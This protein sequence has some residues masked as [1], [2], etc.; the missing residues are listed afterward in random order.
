M[1]E[2]NRI[3]LTDQELEDL[4]NRVF[5]P[6][7]DDRGVAVLCDLPDEALGEQEDWPWRRAT[8]RAWVEQIRRSSLGLP[9]ELYLYRNVHANNADLP[10]HACRWPGGSLPQNA[11]ALAG[12]GWE[13]VPFEQIFAQASIVLAPT[14]LS[15]TAPLKLAARREAARH[16]FR[17]ATLPGFNAAMIPALRLDYGEIDRRVRRLQDLLARAEG[18]RLTFAAF[19]REHE[20]F[21]DLRHRPAHASSGLCTES[22]YA[23]NVPS[24]EAYITPYEGERPDDPSRSQGVLPVELDGEV[25]LYQVVANKAVAVLGQGRVAIR[26]AALLAREPAYGNMAELGLGVLA[27]F[28]IAAIGQT[29]LDEKLGLHVAFGRSDHFG[30]AVGPDDFTSKEAVVHLDRVYL[31]SLQPQIAVPAVD[32]VLPGGEILPL[33]RDAAYVCG[34]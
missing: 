27:D 16:L 10:T 29:L 19:G 14:Q 28:G 17:A 1:T 30:G 18:A 24:G 31:P 11:A 7:A 32:L 5:Q 2:M 26:E 23:G 20:L 4:L 22:G 25:V 6:R 33:M 12:A 3:G 13:T 34:W 8:A 9:A 15:A 21:L